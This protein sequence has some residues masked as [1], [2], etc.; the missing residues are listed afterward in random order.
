MRK[1]LIFVVALSILPVP[2]H[3]AWDFSKSSI[4]VE[5]I[6]GG[7]PSRD[8]IPALFNPE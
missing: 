7:G 4:P 2:V 6:R 3:A 8:G 5:D 1:I